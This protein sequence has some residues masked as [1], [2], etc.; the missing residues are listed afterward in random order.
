MMPLRM[1]ACPHGAQERVASA[2]ITIPRGS[3]VTG[4]LYFQACG[5]L[6]PAGLKEGLHIF[7]P[8]LWGPRNGAHTAHT[9]GAPAES[10]LCHCHCGDLGQIPGLS[11]PVLQ[12]RAS[13]DAGLCLEVA[14]SLRSCLSPAPGTGRGVPELG[15][16]GCDRHRHRWHRCPLRDL[17]GLGGSLAPSPLH[18]AKVGR[19]NP[20]FDQILQT[21]EFTARAVRF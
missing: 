3:G 4:L 13:A 5:G 18:G 20:G 16:G 15:K 10:G 12:F 11:L 19:S 21:W 9:H 2:G 17:G 14:V 1:L 6:E 8:E 7:I